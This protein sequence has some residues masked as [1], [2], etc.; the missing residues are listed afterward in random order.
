LERDPCPPYGVHRADRRTVEARNGATSS[1]EEDVG[2]DF[3]LCV[4]GA[5]IHVQHDLPLRGRLD[6]VSVAQRE[7]DVTVGEIDL[8]SVAS[9]DVP[10]EAAETDAVGGVAARPPTDAAARADGVAVTAFEIAP[11][12][13]PTSKLR[14][15]AP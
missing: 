14:H 13:S 6:I 1:T 9:G 8:V 10:G 2:E 4:V 12:H 15:D 3:V 7:N 5:V 11:S